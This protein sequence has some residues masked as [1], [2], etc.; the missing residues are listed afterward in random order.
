M[1]FEMS[2]YRNL[3]GAIDSDSS[4]LRIDAYLGR[5]FPFFSRNLWKKRLDAGEVLVSGKVARPRYL[6]REGDI[7]QLYHPEDRE[8]EVDD[9][10]QVLYKSEGVMCVY[11]PSGLPMHEGGPYRKN[12]FSHVV[13]IKIGSEWSAVH[14]LDRET[15]GIVICCDNA[16]A[17]DSLAQQLSSQKVNKEYLAIVKGNPKVNS[18]VVDQPIGD[19]EDSEVRI[20]K[21]V[22][23]GGQPS[24][25]DFVVEDLADG[26]SLLRVYPK[27]GRTNQIRIHAAY[28]GHRLLGDKLYYPDEKIFIEFHESGMSEFIE[29]KTGFNRCCLH[30]T[31][32]KFLHPTTDKEVYVQCPMPEDMR[33]LWNRLKHGPAIP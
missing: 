33:L 30:A 9:N 11:K 28:C 10:I 16:A 19:L 15:S 4:G 6:L 32:I 26:H 20:K 21:W 3:G 27:T 23:P 31:A 5:Q 8:P 7:I 29:R 25:S 2:Q 18:W 24:R 13:K 14:R 1:V 22:V 17:R 12:T